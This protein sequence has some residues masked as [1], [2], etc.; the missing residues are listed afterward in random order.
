MLDGRLKTLIKIHGGILGVRENPAHRGDD[1]TGYPH[2]Y[3]G[4]E[5]YAFEDTVERGCTL[6]EAT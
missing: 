2:R 5:P 1:P 4:G 6:E 3:G